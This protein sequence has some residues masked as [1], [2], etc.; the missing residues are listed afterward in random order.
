[1][2]YYFTKKKKKLYKTGEEFWNI[3][4]AI[5]LYTNKNG[6]Y[7]LSNSTLA[8]HHIFKNNHRWNDL[9]VWCLLKNIL[10]YNISSIN[11]L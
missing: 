5:G 1:M 10:V 3:E 2:K 4:I 8:S 11:N 7:Y 6:W 9:K